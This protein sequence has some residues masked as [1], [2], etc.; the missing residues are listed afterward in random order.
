MARTIDTARLLK[1]NLFILLL[2]SCVLMAR[3]LDDMVIV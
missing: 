3:D 1:M 2:A